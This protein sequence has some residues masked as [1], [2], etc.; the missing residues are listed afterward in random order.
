MDDWSNSNLWRYFAVLQHNFVG[1]GPLAVQQVL[2]YDDMDITKTLRR[3]IIRTEIYGVICVCAQTEEIMRQLADKIEVKFPDVWKLLVKLR[4]VDDFGKSC[5]TAN[6]AKKLIEN[7]E[8]VLN[9]VQ[10]KVKGWAQTGVSPP[11]DLTDD[12]ASVTF[13][14]MSWQ[15]LIDTFSLCIESIHF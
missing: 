4:Y 15:P 14:G 3:G 11:K 13:A 2:W 10:M 8:N 7:T 1:G 6:E 5:K 9:T 12:G